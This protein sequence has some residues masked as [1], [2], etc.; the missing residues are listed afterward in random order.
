MA[1]AGGAGS[2]APASAK[3]IESAL[4]RAQ[5]TGTLS[6]QGKGLTTFPM[7]LCKFQELQLIENWWEANPLVKV[8]L[9]NNEIDSI[10]EELAT[11]EVSIAT[12]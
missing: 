10:P 3:A 12:C 6:L 4:K 8:D 11:Q 2:G 9:S 7:D 1:A 5:Q